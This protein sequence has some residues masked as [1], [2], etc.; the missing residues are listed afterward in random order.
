MKQAGKSFSKRIVVFSLLILTLSAAVYVNWRY[1]AADGDLNLAAALSVSE[2]T[3]SK[4]NYLGEAEFVNSASEDDYFSK[5]R[6]SRKEEREKS[7]EEMKEILNNVKSTEEA[8]LIASEKI[9]YYTTLSEKENSIE[10]LIKAK[11]FEDCVAVLSDKSIS[12]VVK[13]DK[14]GLAANQTAQIQDIVLSNCDISCENIKI[15]EIK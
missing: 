8:K 5:T 14:S 11:G 3:T 9:A 12:C 10:S 1:G 2:T 6:T 13:T 7:I 4:E 15:I